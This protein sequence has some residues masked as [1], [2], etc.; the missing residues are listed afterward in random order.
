[1]VNDMD[2]KST[3]KKH[4]III[5]V[6][7]VFSVLLLAGT[8]YALFFQV[9]TNSENQVVKTGKLAITY[10]KDSKKITDVSLYPMSDEDALKA[11]N[12]SSKVEIKNTGSLPANYQIK[13]GKDIDKFKEE[14]SS[15]ATFVN[16][17]Y[18]KVAAYIG[19]E[20]IVAPT[21]IN[22]LNKVGDDNDTFELFKGSLGVD[23]SKEV[24]VK[25]W[26]S[27]DIPETEIGNYL[28]LKLDVTSIVD[29]ANT[30]EGQ[31]N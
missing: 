28:Y 17:D 23:E 8:S 2:Y 12:V 29:E 26:L 13:I 19:E 6:C 9:N 3:I 31:T 27:E 21:I 16:L 4:G 15:N 5:A 11:N 20:E 18:V 22:Q 25:V 30:I 1:M 14:T 7:A 10:G 24:V